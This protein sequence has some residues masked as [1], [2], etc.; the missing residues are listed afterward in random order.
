MPQVSTPTAL[1]D[2]AAAQ[3]RALAEHHERTFGA[4]PLSDQ[5]L[6]QLHSTDVR[7]VVAADGDAVVG[8]AQRAGHSIEIVGDEPTATLLLDALGPLTP[9]DRIW[10]HGQRSPLGAALAARGLHVERILHRLSR[11]LDEPPT[12]PPSPD[13]V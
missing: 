11:R 13:G 5:A 4:P 10:A 7:H 8:Y 1:D 6:T 3:I 12:L 9:D 2:D